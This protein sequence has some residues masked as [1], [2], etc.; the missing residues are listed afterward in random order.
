M[1]TS[2]YTALGYYIEGCG[3]PGE[4]KADD[5]FPAQHNTA[6]LAEDRWLV[7][8]ETRGFRGNDDNRSVVYHLRQDRPDGPVLSEGYLDPQ[9]DN[10]DPLGDGRRFVKL[11]NHSVVFGVPEGAVLNR[12]VP[13]HAGHFAAA[14]RRNPRILDR[15]RDYLLSERE[16]PLPSAA[17]RCVWCQ[18][19]LNETRDDI[20]LTQA[21]QPLLECGVGT[22]A[23]PSRHAA[24]TTMNQGYVNPVP[25][26]SRAD[27]WAFLL[28]WS[29]GANEDTGVCTPIRFRWNNAIGL[30]EWVETG[31]ILDGPDGMG[32]FEGCI[33]PY[34]D[35][36]LVAARI[37]PRTHQGVVWF[38]TND[39]FGRDLRPVY[40]PAI[41]CHGPRTVYRG[42]DGR[43][44]VF[45]T[46]H[47]ASP[48]RTVIGPDVRMPLQAF[49]VDPD[50]DFAVTDTQVVY[51]GFETGLPMREVAG[52]TAHFCRLVPHTGGQHGLVT[53]SVRPKALKHPKPGALF[54]GPVLR[55]E[56]RASG[57]HA[58]RLDYKEDF[59]PAWSFAASNAGR[60]AH[61]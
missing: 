42:P 23:V 27:E 54:K 50:R 41:R 30:Y 17:Y 32:L 22:T 44:R 4:T 25:L 35:G 40:S 57:V 31:P 18:F 52:P 2:V 56:M 36:W 8:F 29:Q 14:W 53:Y 60:F 59:P 58:S 38:R 13:S 21:V 5:V 6:Q 24:L 28:H 48:Y 45:A 1:S 3:I 20:E 11:C 51:D 55:E 47:D 39:L 16:E 49:T 34:R 43:I 9:V 7:I 19:R 12:E 46:D 33:A 61:V 10:W 37:T 15:T 26:S